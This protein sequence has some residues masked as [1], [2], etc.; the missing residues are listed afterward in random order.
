MAGG[1]DPQ[2]LYELSADLPPLAAPVLVQ[3]LDSFID[4]GAA[5]QLTRN[6]LLAELAVEVARFDLDRLYDYRG[7]RPPMLFVDDHWQSYE[8]PTLAVYRIADANGTPY[9]LLGGPEP[10]LHWERFT[11]AVTD[12]VDRLG[13]RLVIGLDAIPM[14]V[15]HTRPVGV[16]AHG[17]RAELIEGFDKFTATVQVPGTVGHLLEYRLGQRGHD[18][19]GFAAQVP[20]YL[21]QSEYPAA[22]VALL[23]AISAASELALPADALST[24][25]EQTRR[26]IDEKVAQSTEAQQLVQ[27]VEAQYDAFLAQRTTLPT[28]DEIGAEL[29]RFLAERPDEP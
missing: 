23:Q 10:D 21:A 28:A 25:A 26:L 11:E 5:R 18:V 17:S 20:H 8:T 4:A 12:L 3:A 7:Q 15:P 22:A 13:V 9:L 14:A 1:F 27:A 29:E 24:A 6:H 2:D 16:I 19:I